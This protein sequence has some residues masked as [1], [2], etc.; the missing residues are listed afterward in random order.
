MPLRVPDFQ[1]CGQGVVTDIYPTKGLVRTKTYRTGLTSTQ[2]LVPTVLVPGDRR[3]RS[4]GRRSELRLRSKYLLDGNGNGWTLGVC[5]S[6]TLF[7]VYVR[8]LSSWCRRTG[9]SAVSV[10]VSC[11]DRLPEGRKE[12]LGTTK[13]ARTCVNVGYRQVLRLYYMFRIIYKMF[14]S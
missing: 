14:L 10:V 8:P 2:S 12:G 11:T 7:Y 4:E 13:R 1:T 3:G 6:F 9:R 5:G